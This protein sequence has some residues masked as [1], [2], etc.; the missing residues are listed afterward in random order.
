MEITYVN[1]KE[2]TEDVHK[3]GEPIPYHKEIKQNRNIVLRKREN[4]KNN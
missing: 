1:Q 3:A 2:I 4:K